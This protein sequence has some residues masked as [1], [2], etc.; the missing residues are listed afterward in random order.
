MLAKIRVIAAKF[1]QALLVDI[2]QLIIV[3]NRVEM[4]YRRP[5]QVQLV[6]RFSNRL[7]QS[8]PFGVVYF[9]NVL[10]H[11]S[12]GAEFF[13]ELGFDRADI[14]LTESWAFDNN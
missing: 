4:T 13:I 2:P 1:G 8:I 14:D 3:H 6:V 9:R 5:E 12:A 10:D 11:R 7:Y